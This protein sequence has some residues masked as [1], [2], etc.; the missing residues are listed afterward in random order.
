ME[1]KK[2][3]DNPTDTRM[4]FAELVPIKDLGNYKLYPNIERALKQI[5]AEKALE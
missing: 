2:V 1:G 4:I 3:L 5:K